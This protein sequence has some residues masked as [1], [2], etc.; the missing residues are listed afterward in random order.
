MKDTQLYIGTK[1]IR[2]T[3]AS[4]HEFDAQRGLTP[5]TL[6]E[7]RPGYLVYYPDDYV[8]WSPKAVFEQA[9]RL[10]SEQETA[11]INN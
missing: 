4:D 3:P 2:A 9:Y 6:D 11:L 8:S 7:A 10:V 1:I 5:S